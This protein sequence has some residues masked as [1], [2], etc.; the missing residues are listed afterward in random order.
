MQPR[1]L[2]LIIEKNR[3]DSI[4]KKKFNRDEWAW[5]MCNALE[6]YRQWKRANPEGDYRPLVHCPFLKKGYKIT[7]GPSPEVRS[8]AT[9]F[10]QN[11]T[12]IWQS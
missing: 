5:V 2:D 11:L 12:S 9:R 6:H 8:A 1:L 4:N 7:D 3:H 10:Y